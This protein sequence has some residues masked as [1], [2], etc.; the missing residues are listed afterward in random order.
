MIDISEMRQRRVEADMGHSF[1]ISPDTLAGGVS[2]QFVVGSSLNSG[3]KKFHGFL[4][5][6]LGGLG[7]SEEALAA[8]RPQCKSFIRQVLL[9]EDSRC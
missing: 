6:P 8:A 1:D 7:L 5:D 3:P 9:I 4:L 2:K